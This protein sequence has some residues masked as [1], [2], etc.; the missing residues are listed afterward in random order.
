MEEHYQKRVYRRQDEI[1]HD[2]KGGNEMLK[3]RFS[4]RIRAQRA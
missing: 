4:V 2:K 1:N 3:A